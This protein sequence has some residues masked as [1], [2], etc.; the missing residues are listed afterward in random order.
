MVDTW[1]AHEHMVKAVKI[2][3]DLVLSVGDFICVY[4]MESKKWSRSGW[5]SS[6][7]TDAEWIINDTHYL[8]ADINGTIT[9]DKVVSSSKFREVRA[10]KVKMHLQ[11]T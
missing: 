9:M 3:G 6:M 7:I 5:S 10:D 8:V 4:N 1:Q 2:R 11:K